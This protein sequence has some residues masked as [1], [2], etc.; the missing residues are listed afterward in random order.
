MSFSIRQM[1]E[2]DRAAV[3]DMMQTF[4]S[5]PAVLTNGSAEIFEADIDACVSDSPYAEGYVF[6]DGGEVIGYGMLAKSFSTEF[7]KPCIWIEDLYIKESYRGLG[8]GS[9]FFK[10]IG[11]KYADHLFRLEAEEENERAIAVYKKN[12]F[13]VL[14]YLEM[15][16]EN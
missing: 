1:V 11:E 5:S 16:K 14:P 6:E 2:S 9:A 15:K 3:M 12:G 10:L 8:I 13:E 7:G 4:Y